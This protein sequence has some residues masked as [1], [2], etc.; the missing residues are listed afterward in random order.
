MGG[1]VAR[2]GGALQSDP[3]MLR[4]VFQPSL[5]HR[6][7]GAVPLV[8]LLVLTIALSLTACGKN[9]S[10]VAE[11]AAAGT[12]VPQSEQPK[13]T[14]PAHAKAPERVGN[15][16]AEQETLAYWLGRY[17]PEALDAPLLTSE[18]IT[19]YN[20]ALGR[21]PGDNVASQRDLLEP[22]SRALVVRDMHDRLSYV[23]ERIDDGRYVD[24]GGARLE[25]A[26]IAG[27]TAEL[28][29]K[30]E[31]SLRIAQADIAMR[32]APYPEPLFEP[33]AAIRYDRNACSTIRAT[34]PVLVI[35]P[36]GPDMLLVQ[37]RYARAFIAKDAPLSAEVT[38]KDA[39]S[40][41][42]R[43]RAELRPLTRRALLTEAIS[44]LGSPYGF[45]D[46]NG[47][48]DCSR[49]VLDIFERFDLALPR[50]SGWQ[51]KAGNFTIDVAG[52]SDVEKTNAIRQAGAHAAL[53][54][55][56]P[57][58]I[59]LHL[60]QREDGAPMA[61]H[62]LGEYV[63]PCKGGG[64]TIYENNRVLVSDLE[65]GRGSSRK[66]LIERITTLIVLGAAPT[67]ALAARGKAAP[68]PP[69]AMPPA[70]APCDD[71]VTARV[72]TSPL[73]PERDHVLRVIGTA[74]EA[75]TA[76]E[77]WLF[78]PSGAR[79]PAPIHRL[80]GPPFSAWLELERPVEGRYTALWMDGTNRLACRRITVRAPQ[81]P[82]PAPSAA[83]WEPRFRWEADTNNLWA[84]FVE[85][86]FDDPP[87][88]ERTWTSLHELLRD[89]ERNLLY[90]HFA[91]GEDRAFD[92]V[93]DCA[94]LPYTLRA[95]FAWK[96]KLPFAYR[97]C[98]RGRSGVPPTCGDLKS[99]LMPREATGDVAAFDVFV[100]R[101]VR[102]GVHS[103]SGRTAPD[104]EA[105]DLYPVA[106]E[107]RALPP[108]TVF[109]DPYGHV[110]ILTKWI[111]QGHQG[112]KSYGIL[113]AAEAQPDNTVGRRRFFRG[114]FLFDPS[115]KDVGA[116]FKHFRPLVYDKPANTVTVLDNA[117]LAKA[118]EFPRYSL[119]Q[120]EGD[121]D[122]F[123]DRMDALINPAPLDPSERLR[124]LLDSFEESVERRVLSIDTAEAYVRENPRNIPMPIGHEVFETTGPWE[125]YS[126]PSR[127][128]RLLIAL[129]ELLGL[130]KRV[131]TQP[132]RFALADNAKAGER[133]EEIK[134]ELQAELARRTFAY[135]KT[136]GAK[137]TLR[138]ADVASRA[139][140]FETGYNP[141]DCPEARWGALEGSDELASCKR[142]AP[143][144]QRARMAK[145]SVWFETRSR[146]ARGAKA[147]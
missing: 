27:F 21:R 127:D 11:P 49:L 17:T 79:V 118:T 45:G 133:A 87:D 10:H 131:A 18:Q 63:R 135:T 112:P 125:D 36:A 140:A 66:A 6:V 78:D 52:M 105:T 55:S 121:R 109:A 2:A 65:I 123:Y 73:R 143:A 129:D 147:P 103:A 14:C 53:L 99:C 110:L 16:T 142:R 7:R 92:L 85:Q 96:L 59:M 95:Y 43:A 74:N 40:T 82:D 15:T 54:L 108:G 145:Y 116:G 81:K 68:P 1:C 58:H 29:G 13:G 60:G 4:A 64:E 93:P 37:T 119:M 115:T 22:L 117:T 56:F 137:Q 35:G 46:A 126:T 32:C 83:V 146:P 12:S 19:A 100:N 48:R 80:G 70:D 77:L 42:E 72:F 23:R 9:G 120:Y 75:S 8:P 30:L 97:Q 31:P 57:G 61:L 128:L 51:A 122:A 28:P 38:S 24:G 134:K 102:S 20:A 111:P 124:S 136:D 113:M 98:A 106:L 144:D 39:A 138:L 33:K 84:A 132:D 62:A 114:S 90:D 107:R 94:D 139:A 26:K 5:G 130:P 34:D 25:S 104:D 47:G 88:S 91:L 44:M 101:R 76:S 71:S 41:I 3:V 89:P 86:I 50:H 141:N 69:P 67:G